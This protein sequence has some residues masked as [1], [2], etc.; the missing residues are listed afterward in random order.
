MLYLGK[1]NSLR[2]LRNATCGMFLGDDGDQEVLL[3]N[4]YVP[5]D[6]DRDHS[7]DVF[8]YTDSEDRIVATTLTPKFFLHQFAVL[9]VKDVTKIGAF[10]D[11]GLDKDLLLPLSEQPWKVLKGNKVT[12]CLCLDEKTGR[13]FAS[14]KI[15]ECTDRELTV[16]E[17]EEV[18]LLIDHE[19]ELGWQVVINDR[20]TG[21]IFSDKIF[22]PLRKGDKVKGF[23]ESIREDGKINVSLQKRGYSQVKDSQALLLKKLQENNGVLYLT[24]KSDAKLISQKLGMSKKVFKKCVGALYKQRKIKIESDCIVLSKGKV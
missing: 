11:W 19:S 3:P 8:L 21:L 4:K 1:I 18:D 10:L 22:K 24:D 7:I 14:A 17:G 20:H 9:E 2:V 5:E 23:I 16:H 6:L 12:V 15:N 13:L